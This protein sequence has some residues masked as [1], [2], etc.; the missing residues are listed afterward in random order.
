VERR[1]ALPAKQVSSLTFGGPEFT[2]IFITSAGKSEPMPVMPPGYDPVS[3]N[4]GGALYHMN[5]G[6]TGKPEYVASIQLARG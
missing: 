1:I 5:L 4:F 6:I 3:G 2:D